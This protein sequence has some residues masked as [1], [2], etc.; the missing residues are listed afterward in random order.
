M[1][2]LRTFGGNKFKEGDIL[3]RCCGRWEL[4]CLAPGYWSLFYA[5]QVCGSLERQFDGWW[6]IS[7]EGYPVRA[8]RTFQEA[9][10]VI[11]DGAWDGDGEE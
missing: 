3:V 7:L 10:Q 5:G 9:L 4:G 1:N 11:A 6:N 8:R 2:T